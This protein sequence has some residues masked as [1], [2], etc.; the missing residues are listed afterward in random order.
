[1]VSPQNP[2][3]DS[4]DMAP[5]ATRIAKAR[6]VADDPRIRV[7]DIEAHL[8]TVYTADTLEAL[9]HR[10]PKCRFVWLMGADNMIQIPRWKGWE[11]IFASVAIAVLPRPTY[12]LRALSGIAARRFA[13]AR[14]RES[15]ADRVADMA[16]P[17]WVFLGIRPHFASATRI[18]ADRAKGS[19]RPWKHGTRA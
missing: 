1:M 16:P 2:L 15:A 11:R 4:V 10:F 8:G 18:R 13:G 3:K 7:T 17:A 5:F 19:G 12:S 9:R 14:V 6:A